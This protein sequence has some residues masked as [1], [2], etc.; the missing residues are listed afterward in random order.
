MAKRSTKPVKRKAATT[1]RSVAKRPPARPKP[2]AIKLL[3]TGRV[4]RN[5]AP[6][7][8]ARHT[9]HPSIVLLDDGTWLASFDIGEGAESLDYKTYT[10]RSTDE[11][12][13][14][15]APEPILR[16]QPTHAMSRVTSTCRI[17]RPGGGSEIVGFGALFHR[18]N[19]DEG[20]TN[21]ENVGFVPTDLFT[22]R[23]SD[24]G[25]TWSDPS[26]ISPP[27][28]GPGFEICH[29]IIGLADGRWLAPTSTWRGWNGDEPNGMKAIALV[30]HDRGATWSESIDVQDHYKRGVAVWEQ[31]MT[32]LSDGRLVQV[33]WMFNLKTG[34]A[35][36][37]RYT[38]SND[39]K[40]FGPSKPNGLRGQTTKLV[41]LP[42]D[43]LFLL[44][45]RDDKPGLWAHLARLDG[46]KWVGLADQLVW[47]GAA[48]GM[49]GKGTHSDELSR[50]K[51]GYPQMA[52]LP[53]GDVL[54]LVWC[55]EDA[56]Y[57]IRWFR[58]RVK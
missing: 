48:S 4:Y 51:F 27:I 24:G 38:V 47:G 34:R 54:G 46:D 9:W 32:Q 39:G 11:G 21:R 25:A 17:S 37:T 10:A 31:S 6:H 2:T 20:L 13:T 57:N 1:K 36:P 5:P 8:K 29:A 28:V 3:T 22:V 56:I 45:R 33:G 58:L 43:R 19:P 42:D 16:P 18:D 44:Y 7:L 23:S 50:L 15:S 53:N 40:T 52:V 14:W 41:R 55:M 30:S 26:I 12:K 35:E 49:T